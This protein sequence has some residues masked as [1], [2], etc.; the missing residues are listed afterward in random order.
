LRSGFLG[1]AG[2]GS[3]FL[4]KFTSGFGS[5]NASGFGSSNGASSLTFGDGSDV[6]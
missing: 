2:F 1:A 5:G 3:G 4:I 6:T